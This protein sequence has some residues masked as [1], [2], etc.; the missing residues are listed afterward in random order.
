MCHVSALM[1]GSDRGTGRRSSGVYLAVIDLVGRYFCIK[2][3]RKF[4][5]GR[6]YQKKS[7]I[8]RQPLV[9]AK[10]VV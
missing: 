6:E 9:K 4:Q 1:P 3:I 7:N 8:C 10:K 2:R 5:N